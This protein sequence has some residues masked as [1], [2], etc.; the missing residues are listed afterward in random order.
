LLAD[1]SRFIP[2]PQLDRDPSIPTSRHYSSWRLD[3]TSTIAALL[4]V[5]F[6][7]VSAQDIDDRPNGSRAAI[8][9]LA[10]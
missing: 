4:L 3:F 9:P 5:F 10:L 8:W 7:L 6:N 1:I 2:L